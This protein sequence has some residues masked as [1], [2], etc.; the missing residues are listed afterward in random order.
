MPMLLIV[1]PY[2]A[3]ASGIH[4]IRDKH[5]SSTRKH[6]CALRWLLAK[7]PGFD[8]QRGRCILGM[9]AAWSLH[10]AQALRACGCHH[11]ILV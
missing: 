1:I 6:A 10:F 4:D 7:G 11:D 2:N 9:Y 3:L 8:P 5:C